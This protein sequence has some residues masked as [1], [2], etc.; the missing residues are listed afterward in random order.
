MKAPK[1]NLRGL[2]IGLSVL[3]GGVTIGGIAMACTTGCPP[4]PT[5]CSPPPAPPKPPAPP[6]GCCGGG[7]HHVNIPGVN[8]NIGATVIVN[9]NSSASAVANSGASSGAGAGSLAGS[10]AGTV[11][12][13]GGGGHGGYYSG[14]MASG[15]IQGLN[16]EGGEARRRQAYEATRTRTRRVIIR[17]VCLDDR[18]IPHPASQVT[19]DRD[20]DDSYNGELYRCIAGSRMQYVIADYTGQIDISTGGAGQTFICQKNEALYHVPGAA[21][22]QASISCR[23]QAPA[24]DCNERSLLRRFGAGV[25]ILT[26]ITTETYTAY[27][28][29]TVQERQT[30]TTSFSLD[31]GVGGVVY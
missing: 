22:G 20:I 25:K 15:Y 12:Y 1:L 4:P 14:P 28:E 7:G 19:P 6:T 23:P 26:I 11:N 5:C 13:Y 17:A 27:R 21:Q 29:E 8:V 3:L 2:L 24:R 31:G 16:V 18:D 9:A 30:L 10:A